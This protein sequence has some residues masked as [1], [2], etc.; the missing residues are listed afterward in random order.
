MFVGSVDVC[1]EIK[2]IDF[3]CQHYILRAEITGLL[4][5]LETL[6]IQE[7]A[8]MALCKALC[9][10]AGASGVFYVLTLLERTLVA[11]FFQCN[12]CS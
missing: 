9:T 1:E 11:P 3:K 5:S 10:K 6:P 2:L 12:L 7:L 4:S 8:V